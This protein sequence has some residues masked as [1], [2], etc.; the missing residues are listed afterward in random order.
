MITKANKIKDFGVFKNFDGNSL[1]EFKM[2]NLIY[3]WNYSGKT[4]LSRVFRCL[5][6]GQ[7]HND[8]LVA[9]FE[10]QN[11]TAKYDNTFSVKPNIRVFNSDFIKE[12]LKWDSESI[13]PIFLLGEENIELQT[14]LKTKEESLVIAEQ[15]LAEAKRL[16]TEKENRINTALTNKAREVTQQLSLGRNF[17]RDSLRQLVE[18]V[19]SD[20]ASHTL[21]QTDFDTYNARAVS[22]E[23]KPQIGAINFSIADAP[24]LKKDVEA[25]LH[26][27][28]TSSN[29]IQKLLDSKPISDWV[30][31]GKELH[32]DKTECEFCGNTLPTDLLTKLNEHFSKDYDHLKADIEVKLNLLNNSKIN[33]TNP[34]PTETAFYVDV[35][36]DFRTK[37]PLLKTAIINFNNSISSL[38]KD[39]ENKKE[40]PF[41][42]LELSAFTDN[43][44][45]LKT[46]L[47]DF[48]IVIATN[49]KRTSDFT[50]E[51]NAAIEKLKEHFAAQF[52]TTETYSAIQTQLANEQTAID[53]QNANIETQRQAISTIKT[54]LDE[55]IKGADKINEYLKIFFGKDDVQITST[56]DKKFKLVRGTE[57][58]KNLSEGEK[59]AIS[60]AYFT[61]KLEEQNNQLSDTII[62][63]DDPVSSLDSN[64]LFNIYSFIKNTFYEFT[65]D[66]ALNKNVHKA[67]CKQLFISTHNF[68][69]HNLIF[70]WFKNIGKGKQM[71][72]LVERHKNSHKDESVIKEN[73]NLLTIFNSEYAYLYSLL[74][75]FHSNP[76]D[77]YDFLY[78]LPNIT[79][80]FIETF[81][82]FKYLTPSKIEESI[83]KLIID[84][85]KCERVRKFIH[86]HS[87]NLTT[88]KVARFT[89]LAE[90]KD[91]VEIV[92]ESVKSNDP[93][94]FNSLK[95]TITTMA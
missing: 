72:L 36:P 65:F 44:T 23:Q 4:T 16:R 28:A 84:S 74:D 38:I 90:C 22:N 32:E 93:T 7:L 8:Y 2:F 35:Q 92:I 15:E 83:D 94:H 46:A 11:A 59:T 50:N 55:T 14:E 53:T 18:T 48:N 26:R 71:F 1:P 76:V 66:T 30:E 91:V 43:T 45:A 27:Q 54:K 89:D 88:E 77:T 61:A 64:H 58:A 81:L 29:K 62:Y 25:I 3:G 10:L 87:H 24:K 78:H 21:N 12:N 41:D 47:A 20:V 39:L 86:Y 5:E 40:K 17:N 34:L 13:E 37:E 9:T 56:P 85:V 42:K 70:D 79:R 52:E 75:K 73:T 57:V 19:K 69:F 49:D 31:K 33:L 80:R 95:E 67:K 82:N 68:D 6:K 51:K 60:F 63:I